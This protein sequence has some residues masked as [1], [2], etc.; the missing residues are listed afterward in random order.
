MPIHFKLFVIV[1]FTNEVS[2]CFDNNARR[3]VLIIRR[4]PTNFNLR[5]ILG[6]RTIGLH[7]GRGKL[8]TI[9]VRS[10]DAFECVAGVRRQLSRVGI[11]RGFDRL[12][13]L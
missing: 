9:G 8:W 10:C 2:K 3:C 7:P 12:P 13:S 4:C 11:Y 6:D 5:K 1:T